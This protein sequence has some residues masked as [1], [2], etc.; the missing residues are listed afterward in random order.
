MYQKWQLFHAQ[1]YTKECHMRRCLTVVQPVDMI[2]GQANW[3][4][5]GLLSKRILSLLNVQMG[6]KGSS[7]GTIIY[8]HRVQ[9]CLVVAANSF[10]RCR[11]IAVGRLGF[12]DNG[13]CRICG[14]IW[15]FLWKCPHSLALEPAIQPFLPICASIN[16]VNCLW[17]SLLKHLYPCSVN[18]GIH[19]VV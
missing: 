17:V 19:L 3:S 12:C 11:M 16:A 6:R 7:A 5:K 2:T 9:N 8:C 4:A 10:T 18:I 13:D 15:L 1:L 14:N